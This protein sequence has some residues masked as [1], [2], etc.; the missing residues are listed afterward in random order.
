MLGLRIV[1]LVLAT[2]GSL[3]AR[4]SSKRSSDMGR[5]SRT[6]GRI[7]R[8]RVRIAR[9]VLPLEEVVSHAMLLN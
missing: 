4:I 3:M 8:E 6:F 5:S 2:Q 7:G 1:E 9:H